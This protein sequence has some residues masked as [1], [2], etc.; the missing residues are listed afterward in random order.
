MVEMTL[1]SGSNEITFPRGIVAKKSKSRT[2]KQQTPPVAPPAALVV[3]PFGP[4]KQ[5]IIKKSKVSESLYTL[6]D[7]T[8]LHVKPISGVLTPYANMVGLTHS[9]FSSGYL[10]ETIK[11]L[12]ALANGPLDDDAPEGERELMDWLNSD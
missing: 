4:V 7:G 6:D 3:N 12:E 2:A 9:D 8:K 10:P 5:R 11:K 1:C